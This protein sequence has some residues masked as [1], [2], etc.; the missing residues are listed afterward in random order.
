MTCAA[1]NQDRLRRQRS[2]N[3]QDAKRDAAAHRVP[4]EGGCSRSSEFIRTADLV[5]GRMHAGFAAA[6]AAGGRKKNYLGK[7]RA[8]PQ[9]TPRMH[10][11]SAGRQLLDGGWPPFPGHR[12]GSLGC[13]DTRFSRC[14][15]RPTNGRSRGPRL[16]A[17]VA[18][19]RGGKRVAASRAN[20]ESTGVSVRRSQAAHC[21][22][23]T[24]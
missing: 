3:G 4:E 19:Q 24:L 15:G 7:A 6:E 14:M 21:V 18:P 10:G 11:D 22:E 17:R 12:L 8:F 9:A 20:D 2:L 16:H 13:S 5:A 23:R 1:P